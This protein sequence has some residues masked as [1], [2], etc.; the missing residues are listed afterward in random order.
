VR[1]LSGISETAF[2]MSPEAPKNQSKFIGFLKDR[3]VKYVVIAKEPES[4]P[5]KLFPELDSGGSNEFF[6]RDFQVSTR[7]LPTGIW[8]YSFVSQAQ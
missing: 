2:V 6:Q 1:A 3:G 7:F 4:T 5:R 8:V